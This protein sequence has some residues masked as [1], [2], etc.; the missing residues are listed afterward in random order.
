MSTHIPVV[1]DRLL[2]IHAALDFAGLDHAVGGA[3]ALAQHV[4]DPR[5]TSDIDLNITADPQRPE[6]VRDCLAKDIAI[7]G[8]AAE[9]RRGAGQTRL[10][11]Y[12]EPTTPVALCLPQPGVFHGDPA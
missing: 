8:A 1:L 6:V 3:I 7:H 9:R 12:G 11:W 4:H 10:F 5:G 2:A